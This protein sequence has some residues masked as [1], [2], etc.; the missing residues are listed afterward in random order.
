[1]QLP[2]DATRPSPARP[3][4]TRHRRVTGPPA[5]DWS[6]VVGRN[7]VTPETFQTVPTTASLSDDDFQHR[8]LDHLF[9][10][11]GVLA[12]DGTLLDANRAPL[13][14]AGLTLEDVR[15]LKFWDCHWWNHDPSVQDQ[16]RVAVARAAAGESSRYDVAVR[17]AGDAR[18]TI[19]FMLAPMR[20]ASGRVTHLVPSAIDISARKTSEAALRAS[21]ARHRALLE[22]AP[23]GIAEVG[24]DGRWIEV[25]RKML[26]IVGHTREELLA[27]TF[28]DITHPDDLDTDAH[29]MRRLLAGDTTSYTLDKRYVRKDGSLVWARLTGTIVRDAGGQAT[30]FI[31]VVEDISER[32]ASEQARRHSDALF[33]EVVEMAPSGLLMVDGDGRIVLAN[34]A[35]TQMFGYT[36]KEMLGRAVESLVPSAARDRHAE[37]RV[38]FQAGATRR[39]MGLGRELHAIRRD[40]SAF[41]V[42]IG[43]NPVVTDSGA[44][45]L[46]AILDVSA[47]HAAQAQL[48]AALGEKTVLLN[49]VH[50]RVKN[51]LQVV[52]SLLSLQ[53]MHAPPEVRS[54]LETSQG[55]LR[56]MGLI[57]QLL[58]ESKD[59]RRVQLGDYLRRLSNLLRELHGDARSDI[60]LTLTDDGVPAALDLHRA[61]PCGLIVTE[62]VANAFKHAFP[63][64][65][66]GRI[67]I[68]LGRKDGGLTIVV[69]DNGI[70]LPPEF[71]LAGLRSLG[72]RLV[73]V[74][75]E[76]LHGTL[77][78]GP[79]PG[80]AITITL[81]PERGD[82]ST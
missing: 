51:N 62:L 78:I 77:D 66:A 38:A 36:R 54:A 31:A 55:R 75:V 17:L 52:S 76:Q 70:G 22:E 42:E 60:V 50:H 37:D 8:V 2:K 16:L 41:P 39:A 80:T 11:V 46:S 67:D 14:A 74:L 24:L 72:Y 79:G 30:H 53:A 12:P 10:F 29:E 28:Q 26:E 21:E 44:W 59:Y 20:D 7:T 33:R 34:E 82:E 23:V 18:I 3:A 56:A 5:I 43:L 47:R 68:T 65:R 9:A 49:E 73:P 25:N 27:L 1:M 32:R 57:H 45:I 13:D 81:P 71:R 69:A 64:G 48:E 19:D 6:G 40:G 61:V 63:A 15:G 4:D 58:Y 35:A